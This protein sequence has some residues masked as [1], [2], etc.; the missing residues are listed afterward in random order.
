VIRAALAAVALIAAALPA[1][2]AA[3][4]VSRR[5][6]DAATGRSSTKLNAAY[7]Y[8][9]WLNRY[10]HIAA[11]PLVATSLSA[12]EDPQAKQGRLVADDRPTST[13]P[14][15]SATRSSGSTRARGR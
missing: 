2:A 3:Q 13:G 4:I 5:W 7:G 6:V 12:A 10:G 11:D 1:S 14:S 9:W 15:G 8:L